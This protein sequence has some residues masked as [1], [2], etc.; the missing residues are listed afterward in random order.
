MQLSYMLVLALFSSVFEFSQLSKSIVHKSLPNTFHMY[1]SSWFTSFKE[2]FS[3]WLYN[4]MMKI[5]YSEFI[6]EAYPRNCFM[7]YIW[8]FQIFRSMSLLGFY[9]CYLNCD[10]SVAVEVYKCEVGTFS[11]FIQNTFQKSMQEVVFLF[12]WSL[13]VVYKVLQKL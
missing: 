12:S 5:S 2:T 13:N 4:L 8:A 6:W 11:S 7:L 3:F 9:I 1:F 10:S